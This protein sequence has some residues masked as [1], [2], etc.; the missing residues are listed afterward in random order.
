MTLPRALGSGSPENSARR[1]GTY[2]KI[3]RWQAPCFA[4]Y[5]PRNRYRTALPRLADGCSRRWRRRS[6]GNSRRAM[7]WRSRRSARQVPDVASRRP[8][9]PLSQENFQNRPA[10]GLTC[11]KM[12]YDGCRKGGL[13]GRPFPLSAESGWGQKPRR[14]RTGKVCPPSRA[15]NQARAPR[16]RETP[17]RPRT[18]AH[19]N[20]AR[21]PRAPRAEP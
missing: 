5:R 3:R 11:G 1:A 20:R 17:A 7:S 15:R 6:D 14:E 16:R 21:N 4:A 9:P 12:W 2:R 13:R 19:A 8:V 18:G 10:G